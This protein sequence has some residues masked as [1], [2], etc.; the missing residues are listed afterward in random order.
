MSDSSIPETPLRRCTKCQQEF[1]AT[2]EYFNRMKAGKYGLRATCRECQKIDGHEWYRNNTEKSH[3]KTRRWQAA[4]PDKVR[5]YNHNNRMKNLEDR[6][7]R[8]RQWHRTNAERSSE[9]QMRFRREHRDY[10]RMAS[11]IRR[12]R[13][14]QLI[15]DFTVEQWENCLRYWNGVCCYC[16]AQQS[17]FHTIEQDHFVSLTAGGGYTAL[18]IVPA[19]KSCNISKHNYDARDWLTRRFGKRRAAQILARIESYFESIKENAK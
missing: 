14:R 18:N 10:I 19:C 3:A 17:F 6:R 12:Q 2:P 13:K 16:G 1:P 9:Y 8:S 11:H 15:E 4:N 7:E 5:L